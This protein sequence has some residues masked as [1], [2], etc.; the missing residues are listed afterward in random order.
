MRTFPDVCIGVNR[1]VSPET[2]L[3]TGIFEAEGYSVKLN[4]PF[5][6]ALVPAAFSG[7]DR[8]SS[9]MIELNRR[10]YDNGSFS[11]VRELCRRI[12]ENLNACRL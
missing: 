4:E 11:D 8:V 10:I 1:G 3:I 2:E 7:D 12:Y 5:A 9:V 6:G